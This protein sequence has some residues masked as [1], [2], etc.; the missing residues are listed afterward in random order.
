MRPG[1]ILAMSPPAAASRIVLVEAPPQLP[2]S[3]ARVRRFHMARVA[4]NP[5][6]GV[7]LVDERFAHLRRTYD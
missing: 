5:P 4:V 3:S 2:G 6:R 7:R 1:T